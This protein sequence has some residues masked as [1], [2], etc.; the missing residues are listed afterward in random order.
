[1]DKSGMRELSATKRKTYSLRRDDV[2]L[3]G[4]IEAGA[5]RSTMIS[6]MR[7]KMPYRAIPLMRLLLDSVAPEVNTISLG[8]APINEATFYKQDAMQVS[9]VPKLHRIDSPREQFLQQFQ[10]PIRNGAFS[11]ED[12]HTAAC[13]TASSRPTLAGPLHAENQ[14]S[15][16]QWRWMLTRSRRLHIEVDRSAII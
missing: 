14:R 10:T 5:A 3:L 7:E 4:F 12:C 2:L 6:G 15:Q 16:L 11:N 9:A 8:S 13:R 1:M